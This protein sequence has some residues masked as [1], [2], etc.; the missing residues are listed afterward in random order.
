MKIT[1]R[2]LSLLIACLLHLIIFFILYSSR[3][4]RP[5][6]ST[7]ARVSLLSI[8]S[9]AA[10]TP[11]IAPTTK[12]IALGNK[13]AEKS[14]SA[15]QKNQLASR[16]N[17]EENKVVPQQAAKESVINGLDTALSSASSVAALP[18]GFSDKK[19]IADLTPKPEEKRSLLAKELEKAVRPDC[20]TA[21][22]GLGILAPLALVH[23]TIRDKGCQW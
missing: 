22:Q 2:L 19:I 6:Q 17:A 10:R 7:M 12:A 15:P 21:Y 1:S 8:L 5:A 16:E 3:Q 13:S 23:D 14:H 20:K 11:P 9:E 4:Y 18:K